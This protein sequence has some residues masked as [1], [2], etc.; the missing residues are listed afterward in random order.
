MRL[1]PP[2]LNPKMEVLMELNPINIPSATEFQTRPKPQFQEV[3]K[4]L[5]K[6]R[7]KMLFVSFVIC[8]SIQEESASTRKVQHVDFFFG[9]AFA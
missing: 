1:Q 2:G 6:E 9:F 3:S 5:R 4:Y 7:E 8:H